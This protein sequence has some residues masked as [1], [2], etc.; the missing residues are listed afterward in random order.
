MSKVSME[1]SLNKIKEIIANPPSFIKKAQESVDISCNPLLCGFQLFVF[2]IKDPQLT[3]L[4]TFAVRQ[5]SYMESIIDIL[6]KRFVD[7][8]YK[9]V[10]FIWS[11]GTLASA[12][13]ENLLQFAFV[14]DDF[15]ERS[16]LFYNFSTIQDLEN[17]PTNKI[18]DGY[19]IDKVILTNV[20]TFCAAYK[21]KRAKLVS[22]VD[23]TNRENY[24]A[25]WY[26]NLVPNLK[27]LAAEINLN[28]INGGKTVDWKSLYINYYHYLC[29]FKHIGWQKTCVSGDIA[30][31]KDMVLQIMNMAAFS[32]IVLNKI[33]IYICEEKYHP[34]THAE[35]LKKSIEMLKNKIAEYE[36]LF[37]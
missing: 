24:V 32:F 30:G 26:M 20:R 27:Y 1:T 12:M 25:D 14:S 31:A 11:I 7:G 33:I 3:T 35:E 21:K 28:L 18:V 36:R 2:D 10:S 34:S 13:L 5:Y 37:I 17:Y 9:V 15:N 4:Y 19:E 6:E 16:R 23:Y 22:D 29:D 8:K